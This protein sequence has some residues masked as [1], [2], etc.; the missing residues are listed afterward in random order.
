MIYYEVHI[1]ECKCVT[2]VLDYYLKLKNALSISYNATSSTDI[3]YHE[4]NI[5]VLSQ[6]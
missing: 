4:W 1:C 6:N 3:V 5:I 2:V